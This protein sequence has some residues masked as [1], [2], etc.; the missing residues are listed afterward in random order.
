[1]AFIMHLMQFEFGK[2]ERK[3]QPIRVVRYLPCR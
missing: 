2:C 1:V 3:W